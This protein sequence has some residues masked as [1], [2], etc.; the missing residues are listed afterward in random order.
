MKLKNM[1]IKKRLLNGFIMVMMIAN[2]AA[3]LG[4]IG[5]LVISSRYTY[6]LRN[7]GFSQ[8]DIGSALAEF[9]ETRSSM[10]AAIGYDSEEAMASSEQDYQ[11]AKKAFLASMEEI[12]KTNVTAEEE[13]VYNE[14]VVE[15]EHYWALTDEIMAT[16]VTNDEDMWMAAQELAYEEHTPLYDE[17]YG[18]L[19]LLMQTKVNEGDGL[20]SHLNI[21]GYVMLSI[22]LVMLIA[23]VFM[24]VKV[25]AV[26]SQGI[27]TPI[28]ALQARLETFAQ[29]DLVTEFPEFDSQDEITE[30]AAVAK[31]M[32]ANLTAIIQD[33]ES[34]LNKMAE[35]DFSSSSENQDKYVGNFMGL[36]IAMNTLN[37]QMNT[38]LYEVND[39]SSQVS[40]GSHNLADA[41]QALAEG[42]TEQAGA[43]EELQRTFAGL[44]EGVVRTSEYVGTTYEQ[45]QNYAK[46]ADRSREEMHNM[47]QVMNR[48]NDTSNK[49]VNIISE[50][51]DIASQTNLLSL[52]A[53]IEAARAGEAGRGFAVVADQIRSLAEQS[54]K[55]AVDTRELIESSL[56]EIE[57]GNAAAGH[58]ATS[59]E[60]VVEG[61]KEIAESAQHLNQISAEQAS[62]MSRAEE[63]IDKISEVVQSNSATAEESSATSQELSAQAVFLNELV[64]RFTL[65]GK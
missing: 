12:R 11:N 53:A 25:G 29:G 26:I 52:N 13:E 43:V 3:I 30:M 42:A 6:A 32:A 36:N 37:E 62:A 23:G 57:E 10:R 63:E 27:E 61:M 20:D 60:E 22:V 15:L 2:V 33:M 50:I 1:K 34:L 65:A 4:V 64:E 8:G 49:I 47:T 7:Y 28:K 35:G 58:V 5:M 48:I 59:I 44:V 46:E 38:T 31:Q 51:E 9:A 21:L 45:A 24:C 17:L 39:A 40:A 14:I 54:A 41:A 56:K 18:D 55:S 16:G 19:N